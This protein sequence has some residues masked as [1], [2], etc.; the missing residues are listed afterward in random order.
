[1]TFASRLSASPGGRRFVG[2]A[3]TALRCRETADTKVRAPEETST[4]GVR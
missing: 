1:M 2:A 3:P 4:G